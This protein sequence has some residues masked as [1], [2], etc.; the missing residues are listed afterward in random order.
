M[1]KSSGT[2]LDG[3][4]R[5]AG[6]GAVR[7]AGQGAGMRPRSHPGDVLRTLAF[8]M[9]L[10]MPLPA[11]WAATAADETPEASEGISE[12]VATAPHREE[13]ARDVPVS[14]SVVDSNLIPSHG[15]GGDNIK[16]L[17]FRVP[18]LN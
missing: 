9:L 2:I 17:A 5:P 4:R 13:N 18:S 14:I 7:A 1:T 12:V 8:S 16:Q 11:V 3:K 15:N 6:R 10:G